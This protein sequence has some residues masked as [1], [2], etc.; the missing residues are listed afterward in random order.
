VLLMKR[1]AAVLCFVLLTA[2]VPAAA[3]GAYPEK[4]IHVVNYV[5]PGGLMDVTSRKFVSIASKYTDATFVVE[6]KEGAGGLIGMRAV[7]EQPADGYT[8][9]AATTSNI[10]KVL[11]SMHNKQESDEFIWG[12]EWI[13][14]LMR[15]PECL[16]AAKDSPLNS[17]ESVHKDAVDK[18]GGQL[19]T[20]PAAGG[21]DHLMAMKVWDKAGVDGKW[22]PYS[23]GPEAMMALLSGQGAVYVG[24]PADIGGREGFN[25]IAVARPERLEQFPDAPTFKE[26]GIAG[27]DDEVMWRGFAMKKGSPEEAMAWWEELLKK[28]ASDPDWREFLEKDGIDVTDYGRTEFNAQVKKDIEDF[29]HYLRKFGLIK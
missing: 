7:L 14:L 20:G 15:D 10:A 3:F 25:I 21:N 12:F 4:P 18:K 19:W 9:F 11:T 29:E 27:L 1:I 2:L 22:I 24:N 8:V 16:I 17:W 23:T 28:V 13:A 5:G 6:N 26:L